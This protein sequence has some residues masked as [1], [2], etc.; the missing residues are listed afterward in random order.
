ML[1]TKKIILLSFGELLL[2]AL[3]LI[4]KDYTICLIQLIIEL[5]GNF[6]SMTP[7]LA[8]VIVRNGPSE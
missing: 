3:G 6:D 1:F 8:A 4:I 7:G 5:T 2:C